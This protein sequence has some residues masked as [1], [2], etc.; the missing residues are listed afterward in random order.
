MRLWPRLFPEATVSVDP[1]EEA[2][3]DML[4]RGIEWLRT[5][6]PRTTPI[7]PGLSPTSREAGP[8]K[9]DRDVQNDGGGGG[10]YR[11]SG[12]RIDWDQIHLCEVDADGFDGFG[13]EFDAALTRFRRTAVLRASSPAS[14]V[15]ARLAV[16]PSTIPWWRRTLRSGGRARRYHEQSP[17]RIAWRLPLASKRF[18]YA[19][20]MPTARLDPE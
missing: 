7:W 20:D 9:Q 19:A 8:G 6:I 10:A 14:P 12:M 11:D 3:C 13:Q 15:S 4:Q 18:I 17:A 1:A 5:S 2:L 16:G